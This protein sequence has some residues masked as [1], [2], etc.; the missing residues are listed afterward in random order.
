MNEW[1]EV[2]RDHRYFNLIVNS[3]TEIDLE[4][5][6]IV[7]EFPTLTGNIV[8]SY[9]SVHRVEMDSIPGDFVGVPPNYIAVVDP[10][11]YATQDSSGHKITPHSE[12]PAP[13]Q[14]AGN[15]AFLWGTMNPDSE[16]IEFHR[17][18]G[19]PA[20][21][22]A[23]NLCKHYKNGMLH[24]KGQHAALSADKVV[25]FWYEKPGEICRNNGPCAIAIDNYKEFW[26]EDE[27]KGHRW[28]DYKHTWGHRA[29]SNI[30]AL[31]RFM[32]QLNGTTNMFGVKFFNDIEDEVCYIADFG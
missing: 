4:L 17:E 20:V 13:A 25:T 32:G 7:I 28:T 23:V 30:N 3:T 1:R 16:F 31:E 9:D 19:F 26:T 15:I 24:R 21:V 14:R 27:F 8:S 11:S 18:D 2:L 6:N 10:H 5:N 12:D 29:R 22:V